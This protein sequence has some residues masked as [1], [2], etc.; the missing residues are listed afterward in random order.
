MARLDGRVHKAELPH[1]TCCF[2]CFQ[3][4]YHAADCA[5]VVLQGQKLSKKEKERLEYKRQVYELAKKR[6]VSACVGF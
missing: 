2:L 6:K 3:A 4:T 1:Y 5:Y